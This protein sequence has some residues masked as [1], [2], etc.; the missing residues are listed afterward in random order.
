VTPQPKRRQ[1]EGASANPLPRKNAVKQRLG[2]AESFYRTVG[3]STH[4][5]PSAHGESLLDAIDLVARAGFGG[6]ELVPADF[7]GVIGS[8]TT[9]RNVGLWPRSFGKRERASLR[10]AL[11]CFRT[12][13]IHAPHLGVNVA[14]I[15]P[16]WREE[17]RRQYFECLELALD[18]GV[19]TVTFHHG[20]QTQGFIASEREVTDHCMAFARE[21]TAFARKHRLTVG[22]EVGSFRII[23][24]SIRAC[25][26]RRFG[27][28]LDMGH[29]VMGGLPP[30]EWVRRL[31]GKTVEVH[32]NSVTKDWS[33]FI[34]HQPLDR[35]NVIDYRAVFSALLADGFR[36]PYM[37]ELR[38]LDIPD[39]I[40]ICLRARETLAELIDSLARERSSP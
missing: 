24:A 19:S 32:V 39:T 10:D 25:R 33:G 12:V 40:D 7:Q 13:T 28:N 36:G 29:A 2:P 30:E 16:G 4:F 17:S 15:N 38:G 26:S 3:I 11:G 31:P 27:V 18:L 23:E 35:N 8:P 9:I 6:F 21:A 37:F 20:G 5:L 22:Y 14:S 34:E 1:R